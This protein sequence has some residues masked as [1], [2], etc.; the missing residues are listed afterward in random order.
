MDKPFLI[1]DALV[2]YTVLPTRKVVSTVE[3]RGYESPA[4]ETM[5]FACDESGEIT[6]W[7]D[8]DA[9]RSA[10]HEAAIIAHCA[11]VLD[12]TRKDS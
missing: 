1:H 6:D 7:L 11:M 5:V 4:F 9:K 8:L 3:L 10:S 2:A 12:H